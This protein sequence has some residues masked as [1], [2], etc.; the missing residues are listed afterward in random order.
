MTSSPNE[1]HDQRS[2]EAALYR[3]LYK[4]TQWRKGRLLFLAQNPLCQRCQARGEITAANVVNHIVP[5][6]GDL[7]LFFASSNWEATC[8]PCHDRDIQSEE[9]TGYSKA[10]G[11][12]G[13]PT[14]DRHP[15]NRPG[16]R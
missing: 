15:A 8:K 14:D 2:T 1:V 13:W 3:K 9:R 4:S 16:G 12:D 7:V 6:K 5:H 10:I 11:P